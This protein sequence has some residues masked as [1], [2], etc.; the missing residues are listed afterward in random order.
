MKRKLF[1]LLA[2]MLGFVSGIQAREDVT[3]YITDAELS[4]E[5]ANWALSSSGGN[6]NWNG[7]FKYRESWHNVF[8]ISQTI[9][10]PNGYYQV[11]I[12]A[13]N[14]VVPSSNAKLTA[15][16]GSNE[17]SANIRLSSAGGF[18]DIAKQFSLNS[19]ACRIYAT[20]KVENGSLTVGFSQTNNGEWIVYGQFKLYSLTET[21]YRH[22]V[23][24]QNAL[25]S[26][27]NSWSDGW[28]NGGGQYS[29]GR[30][31][32][33]E[34]AY[35]AGKIIYKTF[36][37]LPLGN[38][39]V[40]VHAKANVAWREAATG[41]NIAQVYAGTKT[42]DIP[43]EAKTGYDLAT[44]Y[45]YTFNDLEVTT[46][47]LEVG[48][49]NIATGGN[50][51]NVALIN[52]LYKGGCIEADAVA[53]PA[54]GDMTADTWYYFDIAVAG[55]DYTATATNLANIICTDDGT[56]LTAEATGDV[57]LTA[58]DNNFA[59]KRYY[60]KSSSANNLEI[61]VASYTYSISEASANVSCIQEGNTVTVS[62]TV[63]TNDPS[64]TLT[65]DY[66][67]VT[68]SGG[69][70]TCTPTASGFTFTV[71][72]G[73]TNST[74]YTL[75]IPAGVIGY[76][77]G[78]TYNAAQNITLTT[79]AIYDGTY[80]IKNSENKYL[81]RGGSYNTQ[82]IA[83]N[84]GLPVRVSTNSSNITEFIFIDNWFHLFDAGNGNLFTDNNTANDFE[85]EATTGGYYI[86]NKNTVATSTFN[87]KMYYDS[88]DGNRVKVSTTE[89][90]VWTFE[91]PAAHKTQ[92]QA[93]KDAQASAVATTAGIS[94]STVDALSDILESSFA[95]TDIS[96][97]GTGGDV[98]ESYQQGATNQTGNE[99]QIYEETK[100]GLTP[101]LYCLT[102]T[103]FERITWPDDVY[104]NAKGAP[105][106]T[107]VYANN[108][109][110]QLWSL[111]D[112]PS[113][114]KWADNDK[115]YD[116]K[117]YADGTGGANAAF[118]A[119][120]YV[121]KVFVYV[122]D[123]GEGTGSVHFGIN[124]PHRY[125]NDGSRG[126]WICY[127]NFTL[128]Y[129]GNVKVTLGTEG[130]AT[131]GSQYPLNLIPENL[132][133]GVKAYKATSVNGENIQFVALEQCVPANTGLLIAGEA[134][135]VVN[136]PIATSSSSV[137]DNLLQVNAS[138]T[139]FDKQA[140]C[141]YYGLLKN[142]KEFRPFDPASVAIPADK[143]YLKVE[144]TNP[145]RLVISFD[146]EEPTGINAIEVG[147]AKAE[148]LKDGKYLIGGKIVMVK[149]NVKYNA[150]GQILK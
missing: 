99:L 104:Y 46:G 52:L 115:K 85:V 145:A 107:Y 142:T 18:A 135:Q 74:E 87:G 49:Q 114:S 38:Y 45:C 110:I 121:N 141:S 69:A 61:G 53:L 138:G 6:H 1:L 8:S 77:A 149:N 139:T 42:Y 129:Y 43:V 70:I 55:N 98:R 143:A 144:N 59:A 19:E 33:N 37:N 75:S 128:T 131:F 44:E 146:E 41:D 81:S 47:N 13:V 25:E 137:G 30:E 83:D 3:S 80:F 63:S 36:G 24:L 106:L 60:V 71:P 126:A 123:E 58:T 4:N 73:L 12:Q 86:I 89:S 21:E 57:T 113:D 112:F 117:Y 90:T 148:G 20:V 14:S 67:G 15:V 16:S 40:T 66:S 125:G 136:I 64:A 109:K 51:Y 102:V 94:A 150:N 79:P 10:V 100:S 11:S 76:A 132:A 72:D 133:E 32:F 116:G 48:I 2:L 56:Q 39:D 134:N 34:T 105:G 84:K 147:D 68:F 97:T 27:A 93:V 92:M 122:T 111:F 118:A 127:N 54:N 50:W 95:G 29:Y 103:A 124:K 82:A 120:N 7:D 65:Q 62:Y 5:T 108:E 17:A 22:A 140:G 31:R 88:S 96:I 101:G 35:E 9:S 26:N 130:Y 23:I 119:G 91:T 28:T 78:S